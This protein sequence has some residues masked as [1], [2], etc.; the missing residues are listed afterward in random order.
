LD[1]LLFKCEVI[2]LQLDTLLAENANKCDLL[3]AYCSQHPQLSWQPPIAQTLQQLQRLCTVP[4]QIARSYA[5]LSSDSTGLTRTAFQLEV[6]N[7]QLDAF[8]RSAAVMSKA[9]QQLFE[10][11]GTSIRKS[12]ADTPA[13]LAPITPGVQSGKS[14]RGTPRLDE[15]AAG[16]ARIAGRMRKFVLTEVPSGAPS[17]GPGLAAE[18]TTEHLQATAFEEAPEPR[19]NAPDGL[20][21]VEIADVGIWIEPSGGTYERGAPMGQS[22]SVAYEH[23]AALSQTRTRPGSASAFVWV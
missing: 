20:R 4:T 9:S 2:S 1:L 19:N 22:H 8:H 16:V 18:K 14:N 11:V 10:M 12:T 5:T 7:L 3:A 6:M 15:L 13:V 17:T 21:R 23:E